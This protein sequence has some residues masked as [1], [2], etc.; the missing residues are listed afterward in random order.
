[1][2]ERREGFVHRIFWGFW[3]GSG[4]Q[5][6]NWFLKDEQDSLCGRPEAEGRG[7]SQ[8]DPEMKTIARRPGQVLRE[9]TVAC[10]R[11]QESSKS[12]QRA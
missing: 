3:K 8:K 1:M 6:L 10:A 4:K 2:R 5:K 12:H 9:N 7:V 11:R